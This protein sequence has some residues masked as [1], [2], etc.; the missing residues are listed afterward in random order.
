ME[1]KLQDLSDAIAGWIANRYPEFPFCHVW[2]PNDEKQKIQI[3]VPGRIA[4]KTM[5]DELG[6]D[7]DKVEVI[8]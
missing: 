8:H 7:P 4:I 3:R 6:L 1:S 5:C 2:V